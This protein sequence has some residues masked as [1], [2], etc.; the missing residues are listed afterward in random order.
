MSRSGVLNAD[1]VS[2]I[3]KEN[4]L[5][6]IIDIMGEEIL[7]KCEETAVIHELMEYCRPWVDEF[8]GSDKDPDQTKYIECLET[9]EDA[10]W[11]A[12]G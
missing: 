11:A 8:P 2:P 1:G 3:D 10:L 6:D 4:V 12:V 9:F 7:K 5:Y